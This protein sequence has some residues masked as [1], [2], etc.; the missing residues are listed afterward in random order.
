[1]APLDKTEF[2]RWR[3]TATRALE[4]A[5]AQDRAGVHEWACF[6]CEQAAQLA[7]KALLHG[8][9]RGPW[10]HSLF[11]LARSLEKDFEVPGNVLAALDALDRYYIQTRYPDA[12][13]GGAVAAR[14]GADA[15]TTALAQ[16]T[17]VLDW[18]DDTWRALQ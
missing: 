9:G 1:M 15:A 13:S 18:V 4:G 10:G 14:Y 2:E 5:R 16:A 8:V 7:V 3:H 6:M 11:E 17:E 12:H